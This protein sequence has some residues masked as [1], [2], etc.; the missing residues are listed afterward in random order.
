M[1]K[2]RFSRLK[3]AAVILAVVGAA[4]FLFMKKKHEPE[5]IQTQSNK[6][7]RNEPRKGLDAGRR[8]MLAKKL[9]A[10]GKALSSAKDQ[11]PEKEDKFGYLSM[12][13]RMYPPDK[14]KCN[15]KKLTKED[16]QTHGKYFGFGINPK[17][18]EIIQESEMALQHI[19]SFFK[20]GIPPNLPESN[21]SFLGILEKNEDVGSLIGIARHIDTLPF[22]HFFNT[23]R[24]IRAAPEGHFFDLVCTY[25]FIEA[26]NM[27]SY[28]FERLANFSLKHPE[29][30]YKIAAS[31]QS[32]LSSNVEQPFIQDILSHMPLDPND[33]KFTDIN[34]FEKMLENSPKGF[35]T[36]LKNA[37]RVRLIRHD[38]DGKIGKWILSNTNNPDLIDAV[39]EAE[40]GKKELETSLKDEDFASMLEE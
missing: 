12:V 18:G 5:T 8:K 40:K 17:S 27:R 10:L 30:A 38:E 25:R 28:A 3:K 37:L 4:A 16:V 24:S 35:K 15:L 9:L 13:K 19:T 39:H 7:E 31:L 32:N 36:D 1:Q 22:E 14:L 33:L 21:F 11:I 34:P 29:L 20:Y 2:K 23:M 6:A 26:I